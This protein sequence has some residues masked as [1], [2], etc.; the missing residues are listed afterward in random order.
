MTLRPRVLI[1]ADGTCRVSQPGFNAE[2][3]GIDRMTFDERFASIGQT[4]WGSVAIGNRNSVGSNAQNAVVLFGR[5]FFDP[6]MFLYGW[7][8]ENGS[9]RLLPPR[10][11]GYDKSEWGRVAQVDAKVTA[12]RVT[13]KNWYASGANIRVYWKAL[14]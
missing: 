1:L 13:F 6:P 5:D 12:T 2:T 10:I 14:V 8:T 4:V 7:T 3:A 11:S 9:T